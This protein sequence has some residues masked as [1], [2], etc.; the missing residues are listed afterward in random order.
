MYAILQENEYGACRVKG[1]NPQCVLKEGVYERYVQCCACSSNQFDFN[2][3]EKV[4]LL[5]FA[6][7]KSRNLALSPEPNT[8]HGAF[9]AEGHTIKAQ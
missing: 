2:E 6:D 7:P 5:P 4:Q 8:Y 9:N 1:C 3:T